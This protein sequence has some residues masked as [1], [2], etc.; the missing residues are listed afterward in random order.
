M[1]RPELKL[2]TD[3]SEAQWVQEILYPSDEQYR[4]CLGT[5]P[6]LLI[7]ALLGYGTGSVGILRANSLSYSKI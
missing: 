5:L 3:F 1:K 7:N 4:N 2:I 6:K